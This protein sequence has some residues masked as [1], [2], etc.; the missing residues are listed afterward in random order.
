MARP[1]AILRLEDSGEVDD[2]I[3]CVPV[4]GPFSAVVDLA[5]FE[6]RY[7]GALVILE[8]WFVNYK[9]PGYIVS[10]GFGDAPE[11]V[12]MIRETAAQQGDGNS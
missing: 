2:K 9:G 3:V 1:V 6:A 8:T 12:A 7:P 5:S 4:D 11:A 10:R